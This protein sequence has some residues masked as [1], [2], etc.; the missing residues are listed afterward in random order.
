[1]RHH[2][3]QRPTEGRP[4]AQWEGPI[5]LQ[6]RL[7][8]WLRSGWEKIRAAVQA[9]LRLTSS[10]AQNR[11]RSRQVELRRLERAIESI[12]ANLDALHGRIHELESRATPSTPGQAALSLNLTAKSQAI[13]LFRGGQDARQ[14]ARTLGISVG[15][16]ELL[17]KVQR[18]QSCAEARKRERSEQVS[19][20]SEAKREDASAAQREPGRTRR[21]VGIG[22]NAG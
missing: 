22:A 17:L 19:S 5:G 8:G 18:M 11:G 1:M 13:K 6:A 9:V 10:T 14:I 15:E 20:D 7:S 16:I 12:C 3:S 4:A 21:Q 2:V